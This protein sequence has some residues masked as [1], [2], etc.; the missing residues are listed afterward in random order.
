MRL[1]RAI[2]FVLLAAV[3]AVYFP[4][5][6]MQFL[7]WD[8]DIN[9]YRNPHV[10]Q[11]SFDNL[12]WMFTDI[13]HALRYKP[14]SYLSWASIHS[15]CGL[16]PAGYHIANLLLHLVD[17]LL[18]YWVLCRLLLVY[19]PETSPASELRRQ[20]AS[21]LG[22]LLW[23]LHPLRME[24]VAW[25]TGLPYEQSMFFL[26]LSFYSYLRATE[27]GTRRGW[28]LLAWISY[29]LALLTYPIGLCYA[30][31]LPIVDRYVLQRLQ[32]LVPWREWRTQRA[33]WYEKIPFLA[34]SIL[35]LAVQL[36][37]RW[38]APSK[39]N[40]DAASFGPL[41]RVVQAFYCWGYY[42]WKQFLPLNLSAM[43][44]GLTEVHVTELRFVISVIGVAAIS[45]ALFVLR[46]RFPGAYCCWLCH[47]ILLTP[48]VG[49]TEHP[50]FTS[51][52]YMIAASV[53]LVA[54]ISYFLLRTSRIVTA[55]ALAGAVAA[56]FAFANARHAE[57]WS[58]TTHFLSY[59]LSTVDSTIWYEWLWQYRIPPVL[60]PDVIQTEIPRLHQCALKN[61]ADAG[62]FREAG[63]LTLD[64]GRLAEAQQFLTEALKR[65]PSDVR[66]KIRLGV[67]LAQQGN[68]AEAL[69][70]LREASK[71]DPVATKWYEQLRQETAKRASA[72]PADS[73]RPELNNP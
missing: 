35:F 60:R 66:S 69:N 10:Q 4:V 39:W 33:I 68:T 46:R 51:D 9:V 32:S 11:L 21:A 29:A 22:A 55:G 40:S 28:R 59:T 31:I 72:G 36:T 50:H 16:Q 34:L 53:C 1:S 65:D 43:Y 73:A 48:T 45:I 18:L 7:A 12:I 37:G 20:T 71:L 63:M 54:G 19:S 3:V 57:T 6:G 58:D 5:C 14:L 13:Q 27:A 56:L 2:P 26:L 41:E 24:T 64:T 61:P 67:V 49:F 62:P 8:D 44:T 52:R 38:N 42:L 47:L 17:T 25:I 15:V 23:A 70:C 30:F